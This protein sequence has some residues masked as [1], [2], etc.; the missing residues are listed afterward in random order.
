MSTCGVTITFASSPWVGA[1]AVMVE[2]LVTVRDAAGVPPNV[3]AVALVN[4]ISVRDPSVMVGPDA[5]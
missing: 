1:I 4:P 5:G 3:T 2:S